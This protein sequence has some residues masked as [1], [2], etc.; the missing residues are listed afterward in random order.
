MRGGLGLR[1]RV[2]D[3]GTQNPPS[4]SHLARQRFF[5]LLF[6]LRAF[7]LSFKKLNKLSFY[8]KGG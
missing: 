6:Y 1:P 5:D 3:R 8:V 4:C 2:V 7:K